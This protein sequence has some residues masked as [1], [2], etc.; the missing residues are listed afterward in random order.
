LP[1]QTNAVAAG[2]PF[3][4]VIYSSSKKLQKTQHNQEIIS[5]FTLDAGK[6]R[7]K[8]GQKKK[9]YRVIWAWCSHL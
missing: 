5:S 9:V 8:K 2:H 4:S 1:T 7:K 3:Q 6:K